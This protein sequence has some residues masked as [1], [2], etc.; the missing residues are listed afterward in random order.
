MP[1]EINKIAYDLASSAPT[2][3][4]RNSW[5]NLL[6]KE[7]HELGTDYLITEAIKIPFIIEKANQIQARKGILHG[8]NGYDYPEFFYLKK[9]QERLNECDIIKSPLM[10]NLID[11]MLMLCMRSAD[12]KT[13]RINQYRPSRESWY[14][15]DYS[16]YCT[17][18]VKNKGKVGEFWLFLSMEKNPIWV[19]ELLIW[20]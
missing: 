9:V 7:L 11:I 19:R 12:M 1:E 2:T 15:P 10:Q 6:W 13:F 14:N 16:L 17:S 8:I 20:I 18:Y 4:A 3:V 5:L